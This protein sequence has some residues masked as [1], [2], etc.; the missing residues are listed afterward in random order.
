MGCEP[1][2][3]FQQCHYNVDIIDSPKSPQLQFLLTFVFTFDCFFSFHQKKK[4]IISSLFFFL[5]LFFLLVLELAQCTD[6]I[7]LS[8]NVAYFSIL[9]LIISR[10]FQKYHIAS[11]HNVSQERKLM[12][13]KDTNYMIIK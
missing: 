7:I 5:F 11:L 3:L 12:K 1:N 8:Y 9:N 10:N 2:N 4:K 13:L 6:N